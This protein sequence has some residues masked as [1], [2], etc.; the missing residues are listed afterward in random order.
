MINDLIIRKVTPEDLAIVTKVEKEC[1]PE[2]EAATKESFAERIATFSD[3]FFLAEIE[4]EVI[5][6]INGNVTDETVIADEMFEDV[7]YHNPE[8]AYQAIFGL[9]VIPK[10]QKQG[11]AARLMNHL[12]E[13]AR[14]QGRKGVILTCKE[15][16][17]PYY[18][19]FG[20]KNMGRSASTHG[21][22]VWYDM[23][24]EYKD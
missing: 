7:T 1:F 10:H 24:L 3:S 2:A 9:D 5:G 19:R 4:G 20:F 12:I 11:I 14:E 23:L 18:S 21:G 15:R 17:I 8:G 22:S 13:T 16:L 6:F